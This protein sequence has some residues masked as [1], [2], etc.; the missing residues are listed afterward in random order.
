MKTYLRQLY[1]KFL[2][3]NTCRPLNIGA[4]QQFEIS[5]I[6]LGPSSVDLHNVHAQM[7]SSDQRTLLQTNN[8][9]RPKT[10]LG[11]QG[12]FIQ[13]Q[14]KQFAYATQ[15]GQYT[16]SDLATGNRAPV[17]E[18]HSVLA[19]SQEQNET[20]CQ[21]WIQQESYSSF[22]D[23]SDADDILVDSSDFDSDD[24]DDKDAEAYG[25]KAV[26]A[27][28]CNLEHAK[29]ENGLSNQGSTHLD[30]PVFSHAT[31]IEANAGQM[32]DLHIASPEFE[33]DGN[34]FAFSLTKNSKE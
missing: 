1:S 12:K 33:C 17:A 11:D 14:G 4:Q 2:S 16:V 22:G 20:Y 19:P 31:D 23:V 29:P 28:D 21:A 24:S 26:N 13:A 10:L 18:Q 27:A 8:V 6:R 32:A 9:L 30:G 34:R 5:P 3:N 15:D 25:E 7:A